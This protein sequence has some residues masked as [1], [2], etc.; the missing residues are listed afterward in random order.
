[1]KNLVLWSAL[2]LLIL[3]QFGC[4]RVEP[5]PTAEQIATR[6]KER[7]ESYLA[8]NNI[9]NAVVTESGT[10]VVIDSANASGAAPVEGQ[11]LSVRYAGR[12]LDSVKTFD[13]NFSKEEPFR[14]VLGTGTVIN[15]WQEGLPKF[16]VGERGR[17]FIP[18]GQ[19][20]GPSNRTGIPANSILV[21]DIKLRNAQ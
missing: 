3:F 17:L 18:S 5:A 8:A 12:V 19:A 4:T 15:G 10:Y 1:M 11:T 7:I 20:Y 16:R 9:T 21:F 2:A 14:F 6:D 13:E